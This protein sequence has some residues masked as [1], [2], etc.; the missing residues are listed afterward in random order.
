MSLNL[1]HDSFQGHGIK[2][3]LFERMRNKEG[4]NP[5]ERLRPDCYA[6]IRYSLGFLQLNCDLAL[7]NF[8]P[9]Q[10]RPFRIDRA[11][12]FLA[13]QNRLFFERSERSWRIAW[14]VRFRRRPCEIAKQVRS[15]L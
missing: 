8:G 10:R 12:I 7:L 13:Q 3:V 1:E 11:N 5:A 14:R 9:V 6:S 15:E 4:T 2:I